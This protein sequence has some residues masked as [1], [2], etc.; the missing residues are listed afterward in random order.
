MVIFSVAVI[1]LTIN[2][3]LH[4]GKG[5]LWRRHI[6]NPLGSSSIASDVEKAER[7]KS[8]GE[9]S[10]VDSSMRPNNPT[11][12]TSHSNEVTS[13]RHNPHISQAISP[14][15][16]IPSFSESEDD[17]G[18]P[19]S[20]SHS[21]STFATPPSTAQSSRFSATQQRPSCRHLS[22]SVYDEVLKSLLYSEK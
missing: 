13:S 16:T 5:L 1:I 8:R 12:T 10:P 11:P 20:S 18:V 22:D 21:R 19:I 6:D 15:Y 7:E 3:I 9:L 4:F 2:V 14:N 17:Y